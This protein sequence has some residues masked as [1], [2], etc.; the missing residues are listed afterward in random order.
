MFVGTA[1]G[2]APV[3]NPQNLLNSRISSRL[4]VSPA[5]AQRPSPQLRE[6]IGSGSMLTSRAST[7]SLGRIPT[8]PQGP[9]RS[10]RNLLRDVPVLNNHV[11]DLASIDA[12][13]RP[14]PAPDRARPRSL[15]QPADIE[16][17]HARLQGRPLQPQPCGCA[18]RAPDHSVRFLQRLQNSRALGSL[19]A[20]RNPS[21]ERHPV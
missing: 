9:H 11:A 6:I 2:S 19:G 18:I 16:F 17:P 5:S 8:F 1:T 13:I 4:H 10:M 3:T 7:G 15:I 20:V 21:V 12:K 14:K